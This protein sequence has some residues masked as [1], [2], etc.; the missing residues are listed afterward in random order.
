MKKQAT[1]ILISLLIL[2]VFSGCQSYTIPLD[3]FKE[4]FKDI[5]T[6]N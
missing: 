5:N 2:L 3:S 1:L 6:E 4:Q